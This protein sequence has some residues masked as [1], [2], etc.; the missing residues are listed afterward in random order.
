MTYYRE[1]DAAAFDQLQAEALNVI[2]KHKVWFVF[3]VDEDMDCSLL[4]A[5]PERVVSD[6]ITGP[7]LYK[8]LLASV[9]AA[10]AEALVE[11]ENE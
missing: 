10:A 7:M 3:A 1:Q 5:C 4:I 9:M 8:M 11:A 6:M 2:R